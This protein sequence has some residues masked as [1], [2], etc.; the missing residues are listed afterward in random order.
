[1]GT[2]KTRGIVIKTQDYKEND[3]LVWIFTEDL[4]KIT[5][6]AKGAEKIKV[7]IFPILIHF[8]MENICFLKEEKYIP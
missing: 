2:I 3:K 4:G 8:V 1:M 7:K 5:A 6:I